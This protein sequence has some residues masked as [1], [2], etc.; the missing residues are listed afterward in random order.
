MFDWNL[1]LAR[2]ALC[3]LDIFLSDS[4]KV[5]H[6]SKLFS[7]KSWCPI[8]RMNGTW[9]DFLDWPLSAKIQG[10]LKMIP[11]QNSVV[12]NYKEFC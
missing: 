12:V 1:T 11:L 6:L 5:I 9:K 4:V 2:Y 8:Y 3:L 7:I 10:N